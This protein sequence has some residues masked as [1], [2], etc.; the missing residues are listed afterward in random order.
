[1]YVYFL[2]FLLLIFIS[3]FMRKDSIFADLNKFWL[4]LSHFNT[5]NYHTNTIITKYY[6]QA[7]ETKKDLQFTESVENR[8]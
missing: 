3:L 4:T 7:N 8:T 6:R 5:R 2:T 1:M